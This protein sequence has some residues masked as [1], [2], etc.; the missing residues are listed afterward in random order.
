MKMG[1]FKGAN[2][3]GFDSQKNLVANALAQS[4]E[5]GLSDVALNYKSF[6]KLEITENN[7][8]RCI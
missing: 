4:L 5:D 7:N 6:M 3:S 8:W 1:P 2:S